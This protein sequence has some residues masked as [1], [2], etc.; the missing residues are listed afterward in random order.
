MQ[1]VLASSS[2][3]RR[4]LLE[5]LGV[6]FAC[7]V[8]DVDET[9]QPNES[10]R[11][12]VLRLA[13][14]KARAVAADWPD[15]VVIGSDQTALF[16]GDILGKPA[17]EADAEQALLRFGGGAVEFLTGVAV[18][19]TATGRATTHV[20][21]TVARFRRASAAEVRAYVERDRPLDCAGGIRFEGLGP[22]LLE[23]VETVDPTA[24]IGLPLIQLGAMLRAV[25]VNPLA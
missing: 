24:A 23:R 2:R 12:M 25:G 4:E 8:P 19:E 15:A 21:R 5:R 1:L 20:D 6:P 17:T 13:L 18:F 7:V 22:L 3:Y 11:E 14:A 16:A 9:P 10:G